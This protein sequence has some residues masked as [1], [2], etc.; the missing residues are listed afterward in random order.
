[1][2]IQSEWHLVP[3]HFWV[4][5][6]LYKNSLMNNFSLSLPCNYELS[7]FST[8]LPPTVTFG[9]IFLETHKILSKVQPFL[10]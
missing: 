5:Y 9:I 4:R 1:M 3:K 2:Y 10:I 8:F 6:I 7:T